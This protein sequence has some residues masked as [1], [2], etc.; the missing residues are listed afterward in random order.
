MLPAI[1]SLP[2]SIY[3]CSYH[4][5]PPINSTTILRNTPPLSYSFLD[6]DVAR[7]K[8][9]SASTLL[10]PPRRHRLLPPPH[11]LTASP[12]YTSIP[13]CG[14]A[15]VKDAVER[16]SSTFPPSSSLHPSAILSYIYLG[17]QKLCRACNS[18]AWCALDALR[19]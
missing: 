16:A 12:S 6:L 1:N 8:A 14:W 18:P 10:P 19:C 13:R 9:P 17:M 4:L 11:L 7:A 15:G 3:T 5:L 2:H